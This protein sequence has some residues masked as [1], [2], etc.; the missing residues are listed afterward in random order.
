MKNLI[1]LIHET[2]REVFSEN[3][4]LSDIDL[5]YTFLLGVKRRPLKELKE[6]FKG[7]AKDGMQIFLMNIRPKEPIY[8]N[9]KISLQLIEELT[10]RT[11]ELLDYKM[12]RADGDMELIDIDL[13]DDYPLIEASFYDFSKVIIEENRGKNL[14]LSGRIVNI[15]NR[16]K[17]KTEFAYLR[18]E[19]YRNHEL[20]VQV[21]SHFYPSYKQELQ[22]CIGKY[23]GLTGKLVFDEFRNTL[24]IQAHELDIV[25]G[26]HVPRVPITSFNN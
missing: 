11:F 21:S 16:F 17:G 13:I 18:I 25:K 24:I 6:D 19:D 20:I 4:Y 8:K 23:L 12:I 9:R 5:A 1:E 26:Y 2:I 10:W 3:D 22:T 14:V 15:A 7:T